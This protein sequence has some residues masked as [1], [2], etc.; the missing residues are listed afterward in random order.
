MYGRCCWRW[1][2][3]VLYAEDPRSR[4]T[5]TEQLSGMSVKELRACIADGLSFA[6]C[7][8]KRPARA[9]RACVGGRPCAS[10]GG[11]KFGTRR[12]MLGGA[13][14]TPPLPQGWVGPRAAKDGR[15]YWYSTTKGVDGK[16]EFVFD[17]PPTD[18]P[19]SWVKSL[20]DSKIWQQKR[21]REQIMRAIQE[22]V[23]IVSR[24]QN[25]GGEGIVMVDLRSDSE[26]GLTTQG[27]RKYAARLDARSTTWQLARPTDEDGARLGT[28]EDGPWYPTPR[29]GGGVRAALHRIGIESILVRDNK[30]FSAYKHC[31]EFTVHAPGMYYF[32]FAGGASDFKE[33]LSVDKI[34]DLSY[35]STSPHLIAV[36]RLDKVST[37]LHGAAAGAAAGAVAG[38]LGVA[39][40]FAAG[41]LASKV[42][43]KMGAAGRAKLDR[44]TTLAGPNKAELERLQRLLGKNMADQKGALIATGHSSLHGHGDDVMIDRGP[45]SPTRWLI[46][47]TSNHHLLDAPDGRDA[48]GRMIGVPPLLPGRIVKTIQRDDSEYAFDGKPNNDVSPN[49]T[50]S[51]C[52]EDE[53]RDHGSDGTEDGIY[54][55][56]PGTGM[57][58]RLWQMKGFKGD[59]TCVQDLFDLMDD[60]NSQFSAGCEILVFIGCNRGWVKK[61]VPATGPDGREGT[62][63]TVPNDKNEV[64]LRYDDGSTSRWIHA[65][66]LAKG[67]SPWAAR[68]KGQATFQAYYKQKGNKKS[69]STDECIVLNRVGADVKVLFQDMAEQTIPQGWVL[70]L[71][72][73]REQIRTTP[74]LLTK[75]KP[76]PKPKPKPKPTPTFAVGDRV[77]VRDGQD[78]WDPGIVTEITSSGKPKVQKSGYSE[79]FTWDEV[80]VSTRADAPDE[81]VADTE[82]PPGW[83][84]P[85]TLDDGTKYWCSTTEGEDGKPEIALVRPTESP[86]SWVPPRATPVWEFADG[87]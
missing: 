56:Q 36:G 64:K 55:L 48:L 81:V 49:Y 79:S 87:G 52:N 41:A 54:Y 25:G 43:N 27:L 72:K 38:P 30:G 67:T 45:R 6:D 62:V 10:S 57:V 33:C 84:G 20:G 66:K 22:D 12:E 35:N 75:P 13:R 85:R 77:E 28:E 37:I 86:A 7:L 83:T 23:K 50:L 26:A 58:H 63:M 44:Q 16:H 34:Y 61:G 59:K 78:P 82:L 29:P 15:T 69:S 51:G 40:G 14:R 17:E 2:L 65:D 47:Y 18:S 53:E 39:A 4:W 76:H 74:C 11:G 19:Q 46:R 70:G 68:S 60:L 32:N 31:V 73:L 1:V 21:A 3:L 9:R 80:R 71:E 24:S 42:G 8:E 5:W